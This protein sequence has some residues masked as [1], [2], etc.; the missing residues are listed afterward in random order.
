MRKMIK[1][2]PFYSIS[3]Q[4][5][6]VSDLQKKR[7]KISKPTLFPEIYENMNYTLKEKLKTNSNI[8][9]KYYKHGMIKYKKGYILKI[10]E[11]YKYLTIENERIYFKDI[12]D[13][14]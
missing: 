6:I 2:K 14:K 4:E 10:N 3:G 9:I 1:W 7:N 12:L 13:I 5:N 8:N 11:I